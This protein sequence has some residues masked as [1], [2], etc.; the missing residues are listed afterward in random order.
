MLF[1]TDSK[2][3][4]VKVFD[5]DIEN[6]ATVRIE[7]KEADDRDELD[8][9][10]KSRRNNLN[11][12]VYKHLF[13]STEDRVCYTPCYPTVLSHRVIPPCYPTVFSHRVFPPCYPTLSVFCCGYLC[14]TT[15]RCRPVY[16]NGT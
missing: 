4:K 12:F 9:G 8:E 14:Y 3:T 5:D 2:A 11:D 6:A 15:S 16:S 7:V 1:Q 10:N 13:S